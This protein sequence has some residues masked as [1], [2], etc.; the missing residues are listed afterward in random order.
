M[1]EALQKM[2]LMNPINKTIDVMWRGEFDKA[3]PT[4]WESTVDI[5]RGAVEFV[6]AAADQI[7]IIATATNEKL[8]PVIDQTREALATTMEKGRDTFNQ[9]QEQV[10]QAFEPARRFFSSI[11]KR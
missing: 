4:F 6:G 9:V 1:T 10:R 7:S 5:G 11:F 2:D 8:A 3:I